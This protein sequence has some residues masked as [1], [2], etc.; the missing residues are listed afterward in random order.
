MR[1]LESARQTFLDSPLGIGEKSLL[2][3]AQD[4]KVYSVR[5][6]RN[7]AF[8]ASYAAHLIVTD[9]TGAPQDIL[10]L[11]VAWL[12]ANVPDATADAIKF[13]VDIVTTKK[14]DVSIMIELT[15]IVATPDAGNG[16]VRLEAA[17][18]PDAHA[19][20]MKFLYPDLPES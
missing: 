7:Q 8:Q 9:Y 19:F 4:G 5:G 10:F 2:T 20:D 13:H 3:F 17:P 12:Q 6:E 18:T 1:L 11:A 15:E 16:L 14:V